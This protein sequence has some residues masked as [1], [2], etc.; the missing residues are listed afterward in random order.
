VTPPVTPL[1]V[2]ISISLAKWQDILKGDVI[3]SG[4][5]STRNTDIVLKLVKVSH[6]EEANS[7]TG[8]LSEVYL[9]QQLRHPNIVSLITEEAVLGILTEY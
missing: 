7:M 1:P 4:P 2:V 5:M 3:Y 9:L 8:L 6:V